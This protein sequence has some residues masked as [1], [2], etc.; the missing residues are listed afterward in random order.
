MILYIVTQ[1]GKDDTVKRIVL[2][3]G[4]GFIGSYL[5]KKFEE[6]GDEVLLISRSK[7]AITWADKQGIRDALEGADMLINLAGKSVDCRYTEEN[8]REILHSRTG[9]TKI[10]GDAIQTCLHPPKLWINA[11]TATIY[12]HAEDRPMTEDNGEIGEGFSVEVAKKWEHSFF[13]FSLDNTRQVAL[14]M[15]IV[16]GPGGGVFT[17]YKY[18]AQFGLGGKQGNGTQMFSWIHVEDVYRIIRFI[19]SNHQLAGVFNCSSPYPIPN[20]YLMKVI[21]RKLNRKIGIPIPRPLLEIGAIFIQ[22]ETELVL[23]SRWVIPERLLNAGFTFQYPTIEETIEDIVR[24]NSI[25]QY[26]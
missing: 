1:I 7:P 23:K 13:R 16:L 12:R 8:K 9:T 5:K 22:T 25:L 10:L 26:S 11:S 17:P 14:R 19:E 6:S 4:S 24:G 15:A 3:G 2:A 20:H 18:L 21:R